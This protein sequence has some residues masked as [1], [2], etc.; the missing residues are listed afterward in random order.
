MESRRAAQLREIRKIAK[1]EG[2]PSGEMLDDVVEAGIRV[3]QRKNRWGCGF[4][5]CQKRCLG[6]ARG[7]MRLI[8]PEQRRKR[9]DQ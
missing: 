6:H 5:G 8:W 9:K 3:F 1:A 4:K 2:R 7:Q